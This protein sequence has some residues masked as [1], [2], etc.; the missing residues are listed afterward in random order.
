MDI[1]KSPGGGGGGEI[2][3]MTLVFTHSN[4]GGTA[5]SLDMLDGNPP[6][7]LVSHMGHRIDKTGGAVSQESAQAFPNTPTGIAQT[8]T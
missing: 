3:Y 5:L 7:A 8:S 1:S 6:Q 4:F 2:A